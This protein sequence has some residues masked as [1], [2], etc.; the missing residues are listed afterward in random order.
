MIFEIIKKHADVAALAVDKADVELAM[1]EIQ[2][3]ADELKR[4]SAAAVG[5][6]TTLCN[7]IRFGAEEGNDPPR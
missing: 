3:A 5:Y 6:A 7:A 4:L 2:R 1:A